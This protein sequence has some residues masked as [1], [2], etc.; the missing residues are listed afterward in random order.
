MQNPSVILYG[1]EK[2]EI[3]DRPIPEIEDG[4]DVIVR[5]RFV[6]VCGSDVHYS[7]SLHHPSFPP[8][9]THHNWK[10]EEKTN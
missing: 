10:E 2:A 8:T 5:I 3:E 4:H 9:L 7:L 1:P 6:G